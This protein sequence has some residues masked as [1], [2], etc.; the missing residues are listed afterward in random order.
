VLYGDLQ[1]LHYYLVDIHK[2]TPKIQEV[3]EFQT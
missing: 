3:R 1:T 2:P